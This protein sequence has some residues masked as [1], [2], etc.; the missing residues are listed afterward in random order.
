MMSKKKEMT[1]AK[2]R[3]A[4][5]ILNIFDMLIFLK[6]IIFNVKN[7]LHLKKEEEKKNCK[8]CMLQ[9]CENLL[10]ASIRHG[11]YFKPY[12]A[13]YSISNCHLVI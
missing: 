4:D 10:S 13:M 9:A 6:L 8:N 12:F 2:A 5:G 1:K 11:I 7:T 3:N